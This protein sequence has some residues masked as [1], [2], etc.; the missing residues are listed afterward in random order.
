MRDDEERH[1]EAGSALSVKEEKKETG[2]L[3]GRFLLNRMRTTT[4]VAVFV[5]I[6]VL[7]GIFFAR[8]NYSSVSMRITSSAFE[9]NGSLPSLYTCDGKGISPP[10]AIADVPPGTQ[11]FVLVFDDPD[12]PGRTFDHWVVWNI[13]PVVAEITEGASMDGDGIVGRNTARGNAYFPPCPPSGEHRYIFKLYALD[14]FLSLSASST[15][16][17]VERAMEGHVLDS[18]ELMGRYRRYNS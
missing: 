3:R 12:A 11:S 8:R 6:V 2:P 13:P 16:S 17:D 5:L 18:A 9:H 14:T 10:L 15:R 7:A 1:A 4:I